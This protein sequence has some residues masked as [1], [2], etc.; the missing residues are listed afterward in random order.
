[1]PT[2]FVL[3]CTR[4]V[5]DRPVC[6]S[7]FHPITV[8]W[9][10]RGRQRRPIFPSLN[11]LPEENVRLRNT[12]SIGANPYRLIETTCWINSSKGC[13][14]SLNRHCSRNS[15]SSFKKSSYPSGI[16]TYHGTL[17]IE[18]STTSRAG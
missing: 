3:Y 18:A 4:W 16:S 13:S 15:F 10:I 1:M 2:G 6:S 7:H 11:L 9:S 14:I 5:R 8:R 17:Q 12:F